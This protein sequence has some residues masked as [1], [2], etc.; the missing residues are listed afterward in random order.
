MSDKEFVKDESIPTAE[1]YANLNKQEESSDAIPPEMK[2]GDLVQDEEGTGIVVEKQEVHALPKEMEDKIANKFKEL[3][4][5]MALAEAV[6]KGELNMTAEEIASK[7]FD[8][9]NRPHP[10]AE[11]NEKVKAVKEAFKNVEV[12]GDG[13]VSV[14]GKELPTAQ[15]QAQKMHQEEL[16]NQKQRNSNQVAIDAMNQPASPVTFN[17]PE[18]KADKFVTSL[19]KEDRDKMEIAKTIVV[20]KVKKVSVPVATRKISSLEEYKS[21]APSEASTLQIQ[22]PLPNSGY[23]G[24]FTGC[25]SLA[26]ASIVP[27]LD[28]PVDYK[29]RFEF[30]YRYLVT[31]NIGRL[32]YD[33]FVKRTSPDDLP[34]MI[35]AILRGTLPPNTA[36]KVSLNCGSC[37]KVYPVEYYLEGLLDQERTPQE[38]FDR[39]RNI[40]ENNTT[41]DDAKQY[42]DS[43]P[44]RT[45]DYVELSPNLTAGIRPAVGH[46][47]I[48]R[49]GLMETIAEKY[50]AVVAMVLLYIPVIYKTMMIEGDTEEQC[51]QISDP[52]TI[53]EILY[54]LTPDQLTILKQCIEDIKEPG[55]PVY[56]IRNVKCPHCGLE[57][58]FVPVS[59]DSLVFTKARQLLQ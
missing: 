27:D 52:L 53:A 17:V 11:Q 6:A 30:C 1:L 41:V 36:D 51:Y 48:E 42:H 29:K 34:V 5:K 22:A 57:S 56:T 10:E 58:E 39:V 44:H 32:T 54:E 38:I 37:K 19:S 18:E 47:V 3:N 49:M 20:N 13:K 50:N 24:T 23:I 15:E 46:T 16:N 33:E 55:S 26:L 12:D 31:T 14:Y 28:G 9:L 21:V 8:E 4:G 43:L 45:I 25:G 59:I 40:V 7:T 35:H 2:A